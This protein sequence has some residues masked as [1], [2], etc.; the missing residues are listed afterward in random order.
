MDYQVDIFLL[1]TALSVNRNFFKFCIFMNVTEMFE[2][3]ECVE[4]KNR[5][6]SLFTEDFRTHYNWD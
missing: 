5:T 1:S 6:L 4:C 3:F 2:F